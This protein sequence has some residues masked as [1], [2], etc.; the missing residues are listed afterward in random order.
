MIEHQHCLPSQNAML[1]SLLCIRYN[2]H[3]INPFQKPIF[4]PAFT[5]IFVSFY[6]KKTF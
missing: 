6:I 2:M 5:T 1:S 4:L 3:I